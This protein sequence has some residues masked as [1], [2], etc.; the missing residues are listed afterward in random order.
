KSKVSCHYLIN[1]KGQI[2]NII[3]D[4]HTAWHAGKSRWGKLSSLN[5]YSIGIELVNPGH[6]F[7]YKKFR[8]KQI[9]SLIQL[10]KKLIKKYNINKKNIVG[11]SDIAP[12]RKKDP[13]EKFPWKILAK[14]NIG[15]WHNLKQKKLMKNRKK[16][17]LKKEK[18]IFF[19][20]L[21]KIGFQ[22]RFNI[23]KSK[24]QKKLI[25]AFQRRFRPRLISGIIDKECFFIAKN[26]SL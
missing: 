26:I 22:T 5:K 11:H 13:G 21:N 25:E 12:L 4:N 17:I 14:S 20:F 8:K 6:N 18:L 19:K 7:G 3:P 23:K 1:E 15:I 2:I 24:Y 10:I 9:S 16:K